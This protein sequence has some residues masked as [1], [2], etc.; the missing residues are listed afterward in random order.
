[1]VHF[2]TPEL[3]EGQKENLETMLH[4]KAAQVTNED[5]RIIHDEMEEKMSKIKANSN[6]VTKF[7]RKARLLYDML[8]D[9]EYKLEW[10]TKAIIVSALLYFI[11][12]ID[13]LPDFIPGIGYIDDAFMLVIVYNTLENEIRKFIYFKNLIVE[14]YF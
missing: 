12:P 6:I 11:V 9:Q 5:I 13:I 3:D 7:L 4:K 14:E 10:S 8:F 2:S 1:M